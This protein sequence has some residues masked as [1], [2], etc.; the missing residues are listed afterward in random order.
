MTPAA[1]ASRA[2]EITSGIGRF[3]GE[4]AWTPDGKIVYASNASGNP[5][6]WISDSDGRNAKQ[7]TVDPGNDGAPAV[8]PDGRW[9]FYTSFAQ[10]QRSVWKIPMTGGEAVRVFGPHTPPDD[11]PVRATL[12]ATFVARAIS[13]DGKVLAGSFLNRE[14]RGFR[15]GLV[16]VDSGEMV[17][18]FDH[19]PFTSGFTPDGR[20]LTYGDTRNGVWN[21]WN[22]PI[23]G[24]A[25]K[26]VTSFASGSI[27]G[28]AW[29]RDGRQLAVARGTVTNDAVLISNLTPLSH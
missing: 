29:S 23:D 18:K 20:T 22:Q 16:S 19:G 17:K 21:V 24:G 15:L 9:V 13:P 12:R 1:D 26:L 11:D 27:F 10:P 14:A 6:I 7:L 8:S 28:F 4:P 2:T 5:D 3:D 25:P